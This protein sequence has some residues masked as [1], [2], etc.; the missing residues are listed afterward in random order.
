MNY[1]T[2]IFQRA[3]QSLPNIKF[4]F[5]CTMIVS[6][7]IHCA[8]LNVGKEN[9][10]D[11]DSLLLL[12]ALPVQTN[13][14]FQTLVGS[15][16]FSCGKE[17]TID[18][19]SGVKFRDFRYF[20]TDIKLIGNDNS[21]IPYS[22][23]SDSTWQSH[24]VA[25]LD[26][27]TGN[28]GSNPSMGSGSAN[29]NTMIKGTIPSGSTGTFK[30]ITFAISVPEEINFLSSTNQ[31]AP[32]NVN[33]MYWSWTSGYKFAK[34]EF[35]TDDF[36]ANITNLHLGSSNCSNKTCTKN[37]R[38]TI[39]LTKTN[40]YFDPK[41]DFITLDINSFLSGYAG[42]SSNNSCM[43]GT[44]VDCLKIHSNL[45]LD[46]NGNTS[47]PSSQTAFSIK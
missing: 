13:I 29:T 8:K 40:G 34:I 37:Y 31:P 45:G 18:G 20:V 38:P 22:L 28:C 6:N 3:N 27:E 17:Y 35:S 9:N 21:V 23:N 42:F 5:Y 30:G 32:L 43:P 14:N 10:N 24:G 33:A 25:L 12:L 26:F 19:T 11:L 44:N 7:M 4:A 15:E 16:S 36:S 46:S 47:S 39:S 2:H 41:T 1:I